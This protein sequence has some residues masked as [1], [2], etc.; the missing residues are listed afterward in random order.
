MVCFDSATYFAAGTAFK[1]HDF[2]IS[3]I[4]NLIYPT[5]KAVNDRRADYRFLYLD[6][7]APHYGWVML[8]SYLESCNKPEEIQR[9]PI[10]ISS[11]QGKACREHN[12]G[13]DWN[14]LELHCWHFN[15]H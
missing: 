13:S 6:A 14:Q 10:E 12:L 4:L 15:H 9:D 5:S 2:V 1:K 3:I 8:V 11:K 7:R